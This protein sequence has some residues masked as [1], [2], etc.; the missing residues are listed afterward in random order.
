MSSLD[1]LQSAIFSLDRKASYPIIQDATFETVFDLLYRYII[2]WLEDLL[3]L[4]YFPNLPF[5]FLFS[6]KYVIFYVN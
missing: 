6:L 3:D 5:I 2:A 1:R 4:H